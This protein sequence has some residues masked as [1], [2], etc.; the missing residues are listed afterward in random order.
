MHSI[1]KSYSRTSCKHC[2]LVNTCGTEPFTQVQESLQPEFN[3][4]ASARLPSGSMPLS[5]QSITTKLYSSGT[6]YTLQP[7]MKNSQFKWYVGWK[8]WGS[9]SYII[10]TYQGWNLWLGRAL[11]LSRKFCP[12]FTGRNQDLTQVLFMGIREP[13]QPTWS[14]P[15][16]VDHSVWLQAEAWNNTITWQ[17]S[18][19]FIS[20][21][22]KNLW[23]ETP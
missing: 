6:C 7:R 17:V 8:H 14:T 23:S 4:I 19:G 10:A 3:L 12:W 5:V 9:F 16:S 13:Q 21:S 11:A 18:C 1:V 22:L 20:T 15:A 2:C